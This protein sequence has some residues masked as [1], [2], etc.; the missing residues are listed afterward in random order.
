M[1]SVEGKATPTV[2]RADPRAP[3]IVLMPLYEDWDALP[4]LL[5]HLDVALAGHGMTCDVVVA[6][7]GS[8]STPPAPTILPASFPAAGVRS[9]TIVRLG[10]NL[11]HQRAIAIG[12]A[13]IHAAHPGTTVV[14]MDS[15]GEDAPEDVPRLMEASREAGSCLVFA[16]RSQRSEGWLFRMLYRVFR[17]VH[18][19]LTGTSISFGNFSVVPG[20]LL[21]RLVILSELWSHYPAAAIKARLPL[22]TLP[23][24]RARRLRGRSRMNLI[25]LILHGLGAIAVHGDVVGVRALVAMLVATVLIMMGIGAV[26]TVKFATDLAIPG[27]A[28]Y[29]VG[30]LV[31]ILL[32]TLLLALVFVFVTLNNRSYSTFIPRRDYRDY[33]VGETRFP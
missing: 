1:A 28:T 4:L 10:R 16:A 19:V 17:V 21:P 7:D 12:L 24:R 18:R 3:F 14:V 5:A 32:Q 29:A 13:Y 30:L 6:D 11:G 22:V 15:D 2:G 25:A 26:V 33:V 20:P 31:A 9:V 8:R 27:W 23:V